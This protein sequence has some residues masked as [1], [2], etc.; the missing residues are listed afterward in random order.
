MLHRVLL[1]DDEPH[2]VEGLKRALRKE[3]YEI[4]SANSAED[5][6]DLMKRETFDVVISDELMP[7]MPGSE[8]LAVVLQ[9]YPDTVRIILTGHANL[10]TALRAINQGQIYRFLT[11]PVNGSELTITIRQAIQHKALMSE[12]RRLLRTVRQQHSVLE[13]LEKENPGITDVYRDETGAI[14]LDENDG[15]ID[16]LI[17]EISNEVA[18]N[19]MRFSRS[20][21]KQ[22]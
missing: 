20:R 3:P 19:E 8:F 12:S 9:Q 22:E 2:V 1:V 4:V 21:T 11:K 15:D 17:E 10:E 6:L 18:R 5:A 14:I 7:G 13:D 16:V